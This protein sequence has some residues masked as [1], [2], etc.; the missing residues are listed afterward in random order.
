[1]TENKIINDVLTFLQENAYPHYK[2]ERG[3]FKGDWEDCLFVNVLQTLSCEELKMLRKCLSSKKGCPW[4]LYNRIKAVLNGKIV[5]DYK[6]IETSSLLEWFST[7]KKGKMGDSRLVLKAR[8]ASETNENQLAILTVF[9][10]GTSSDL[11]WAADHLLEQWF[12]NMEYHVG[13]LWKRTHNPKLARLALIHLP[14]EFLLEEQKVL[15]SA[16]GRQYVCARLWNEEGFCHDNWTLTIPEY[17]QVNIA[18]ET[19][20]PKNVDILVMEE[21]LDEYMDEDYRFST[22]EF[23][24]LFD[25]MG[26]MGMTYALMKIH[27]QL[28]RREQAHM[29]FYGLMADPTKKF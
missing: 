18:Q 14:T 28:V 26:K 4:K 17:F 6:T 11:N 19:H 29:D 24:Q 20:T 13:M 7:K 2:N 22:E 21:M 12:N 1:M 9:L 3:Y 15:A 10:Y 16:I 25:A 8:Y 27:P 23:E 5:E